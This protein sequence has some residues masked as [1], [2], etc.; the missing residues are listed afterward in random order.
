MTHLSAKTIELTVAENISLVKLP[1]HCTDIL[2]LLD[3]TCFNPLNSHYEKSL[4]EFVHCTGGHD[5]LGKPAF[6]QPYSKYLEE[7]VDRK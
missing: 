5:A 6:L 2:Q 7:R 3:V 1:S 4:T